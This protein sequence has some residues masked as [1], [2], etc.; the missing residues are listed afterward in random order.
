LVKLFFC[1]NSTYDNRGIKKLKELKTHRFCKISFSF[2]YLSFPVNINS[3]SI[4]EYK[5]KVENGIFYVEEKANNERITDTM[6][7][8]S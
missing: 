6:L 8:L 1:I 5:K 3:F 4:K 7:Y 2:R